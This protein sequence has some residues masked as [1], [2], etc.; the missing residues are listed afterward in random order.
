MSYIELVFL[1]FELAGTAAF[2]VTG[3]M[4][5]IE[6]ELDLFGAIVLGTITAVGGGMMRDVLLGILPPTMFINP[7]YAVVSILTSCVVFFAAYIAAKRKKLNMS[8]IAGVINFFDAIGL[9]I[10]V[11]VGVNTAVESQYSGN[12]FLAVFVGMITGIG[13][14]MA[15]DILAGKI[16]VV[17]RKKVYAI[18][19]LAGA[20]LYYY[21]IRL[22]AEATVSAAAA[23]VLIMAVRLLAAHYRWSL[24]RVKL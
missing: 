24:P 9:G 14:G 19:A 20:A 4:C 11:V 16:P 23:V 18:A 21:M 10:F 7:L 3:V 1:V 15:R 5:A 17:L 13:G 2:A 22:G 8:R 6:K 12:M